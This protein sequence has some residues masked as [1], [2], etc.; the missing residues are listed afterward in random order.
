MAASFAGDYAI[1][2]SRPLTAGVVVA[3]WSAGLSIAVNLSHAPALP[4]VHDEF[5]YLLGAETFAHG[6]L[7]NPSHAMWRF[8]ETFHVLQQPTYNSKYP[9]GNALFLALGWRLGGHPI[10]GVCLSFVFMCVTVYWML[11]SSLG[12]KWALGQTLA[13]ASTMAATTWSYTYWGGAV[14]AGGGALLMGGVDRIVRRKESVLSAVAVAVGVLLLANTR[15]FEGALVA[16]PAALLLLRWIIRARRISLARKLKTVVVPIALLLFAGAT[17]MGFYFRAVTG[18]WYDMPYTSYQRARDGTPLFVWQ[19]SKQLAPATDPT[20]REYEKMTQVHFQQAR[21]VAGRVEFVRLLGEFLDSMVPVVLAFPL[22]LLPL[23]WHHEWIRFSAFCTAV[24]L[25]GMG[26]AT[27]FQA[28]YA[29]PLIASLLVIYGSCIRLL[30]R[31]RLRTYAVGRTL[32]VSTVSL[33]FL[34]GLVRTELTIANS[35]RARATPKFA[36]QWNL[37]RQLIADTLTRSGKR[38]LV[39]VRYGPNHTPHKEWVY[40]AATIDAS[41]IV[42]ARDRGVDEN[43]KLLVYFKDR[44]VWTVDVNT[45]E[46]P[47]RVE[48]YNGTAAHILH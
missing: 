39:I 26:L 48:P 42:W 2:A 22:L 17:L 16:A 20:I 44:T 27:Y 30:S 34:A 36:L 13:F 33:W 11:R 12:S 35:I 19:T 5:S 6:R 24:T 15:L 31:L 46:G 23:A 3:L 21:T 29:A 37:Q 47:F 1:I 41:P 28:H 7:T 14:A 32:A 18:K 40:N 38:H 10:V 8:F 43:R 45:D 4:V 25:I 9:P